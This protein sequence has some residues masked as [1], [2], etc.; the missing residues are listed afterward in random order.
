MMGTRV[1]NIIYANVIN[2]WIMNIADHLNP[3]NALK[4]SYLGRNEG[5]GLGKGQITEER[6]TCVSVM[7]IIVMTSFWQTQSKPSHQMNKMS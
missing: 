7:M 1:R 3:E 4:V 2:Q 6:K 5:D